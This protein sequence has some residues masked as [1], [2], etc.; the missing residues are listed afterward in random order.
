M[1]RTYI[2]FDRHLVLFTVFYLHVNGF[3]PILQSELLEDVPGRLPG[4]DGV[5][6]EVYSKTSGQERLFGY[7]MYAIFEMLFYAM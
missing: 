7:I 5:D 4:P 6:S 2:I 3:D 1:I